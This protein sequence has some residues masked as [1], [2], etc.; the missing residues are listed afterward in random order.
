MSS[1]PLFNLHDK[2]WLS[3]QLICAVA[4]VHTEGFYHGDIK[5]DNIVLT[6]WNWL[7]LTDFAP[8]KPLYLPSENLGDYEFYFAKENKKVLCCYL[9]PEKFASSVLESGTV[10]LKAK[11]AMDI[12]SLGCILAKIFLNGISLFDL[13]RLQAYKNG[14][15]NPMELLNKI[16]CKEIREMIGDMIQIDPI[17][18]KPIMDYLRTMKNEIVPRSFV[19]FTYY[20][21]GA[22]LN[23]MLT[24]SDKKVA[25]IFTH[26]DAIWNSCFGKKPPTI[27]QSINELVFEVIRSVPLGDFISE[28]N[29]KGFPYFIK[30]NQSQKVL[31]LEQP[32]S[33]PMR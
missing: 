15:Y 26:L 4:Q 13:P 22:M 24:S 23:P 2:L 9:A 3:F 16:S 25:M 19:Q 8:Y 6:S 17:K 5:T 32:P 14:E 20:F 27:I 12:F 10:S 7:F 21:M 29:P 31:S 18:R 30:Y 28:L 1:M 11:Q 33:E